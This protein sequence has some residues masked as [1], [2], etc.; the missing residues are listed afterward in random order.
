M[1]AG[2][3][4]KRNEKMEFFNGKDGIDDGIWTVKQTRRSEVPPRLNGK[5]EGITVGVNPG[6]A[7]RLGE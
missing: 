5:N 7:G 4:G 3:D 6:L 2:K 1:G